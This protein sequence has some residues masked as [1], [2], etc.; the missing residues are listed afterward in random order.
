MAG[1]AAYRRTTLALPGAAAEDAEP[2]QADGEQGERHRF[3]HAHGR[4]GSRGG[5]VH[6]LRACANAPRHA[7]PERDRVEHRFREEARGGYGRID[8]AERVTACA[9]VSVGSEHGLGPEGRIISIEVVG[10]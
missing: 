2:G 10:D 9:V 5:R 3:G 1:H 6:Y 8:Y 4:R 7:R